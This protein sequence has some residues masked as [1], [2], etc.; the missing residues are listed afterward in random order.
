MI[1]PG[2][3]LLAVDFSDASR[4]ALA[5]AAQLATAF[6]RKVVMVHAFTAPPPAPI[7]DDG[8]TSHVDQIRMEISMSE[9]VE[10]S[11]TWAKE[12]RDRGIEVETVARDGDPTRLI[13]AEA[14]RVDAALLV[15]GTHGRR[16]FRRYVL[17]SVAEEVVKRSGRPVLV[18]PGKQNP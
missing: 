5:A 3:I 9:A 14:D 8:D 12:L 4:P 7:M 18:V 16:G 6:S 15:V 17:G 11:T 1:P 2:R 10:L 13:L